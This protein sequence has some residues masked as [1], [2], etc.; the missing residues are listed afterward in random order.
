MF[1]FARGFYEGSL[2]QN[3]QFLPVF[4][5]LCLI[6][7]LQS[8]FSSLTAFCLLAAPV[9]D[10]PDLSLSGG[11]ESAR[12]LVPDASSGCERRPW[13]RSRPSH[14][15]LFP[16]C[17]LAMGTPRA[18]GVGCCRDGLRP[19]Y[20]GA[21]GAGC[22]RAAAKAEN[23]GARK[24]R[25][26]QRCVL[27]KGNRRGEGSPSLPGCVRPPARLSWLMFWVVFFFFPCAGCTRT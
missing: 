14:Q 6:S 25:V 13:L 16:L 17:A 11:E 2:S 10:P 26:P 3:S 9:T 7:V 20:P 5:N 8:G 15:T 24:Q 22:P 19:L 21:D 4:L 27:P 18:P 12:T 1:G 23:G